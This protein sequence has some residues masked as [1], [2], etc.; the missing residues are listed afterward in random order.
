[1]KE[2]TMN[3]VNNDQSNNVKEG[4]HSSVPFIGVYTAAFFIGIYTP[5]R[6]KLG[7]AASFSLFD[8]SQKII[9]GSESKSA[10][11]AYDARFFSI[12]LV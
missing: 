9:H 1:M 11:F 6:A 7:S 2:S 5:K 4:L 8:W 10:F 12:L 3:R